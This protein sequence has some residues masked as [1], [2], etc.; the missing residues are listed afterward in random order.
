MNK[1]TRMPEVNSLAKILPS[2]VDGGKEFAR[3]V[4][5]LLFY[6][7][8]RN[9]DTVNLFSDRSGD[10]YGLDSVQENFFRTEKTTGYQYKF[11]SSPLSDNHRREIVAAVKK[12]HDNQKH[13]KLKKWILVTPDDLIESST[14]RLGGDVSWFQNLKSELG[15]K[16]NIEHWGHRKLQALFI[17][18]PRL[19]LYYY[20]EL[21][22]EGVM[23]RK[24]IL[25]IRKIYD[26]NFSE[27]H[28]RIDFIGMSVYKPE[29]THGVPLEEIYIPVSAVPYKGA[30]TTLTGL[31][32]NPLEFL[33]P[34]SRH[35]VLGDPGSGKSTLLKFLSIVGQSSALQERYNAKSDKR[36]PLIIILRKYSDAL[37]TNKNISLLQFICQTLQADYSIAD[38]DS[39]FVEYF[40]ESGQ[41]IILFDGM[42]EL[43]DASFKQVVRDRINNFLNCY[44]FVTS[45]ITSRIV[46]Y[47]AAFGFDTER[48]S[49]HQ[50][51]PLLLSEIECFIK[52]WY[53]VRIENKADRQSN[54]DHLLKIFNNPEQ[55]AIRTLAENPLLLTIV[56]LV[57][58]IDAV[59]PD[60]RVVLYQKC[61]E[62]L[63]NTWHTWKYKEAEDTARRGRIERTNRRRIENLAY[64]MHVQ[65]GAENKKSRA[66]LSEDEV[67]SVLIKDIVKHDGTTDYA[68]ARDISLEFLEFIKQKAGLLIEVGDRQY[69]F[70]HLTFQEY[71]TATSLTVDMEV[72][73]V[74][75]LLKKLKS[76][77]SDPRWHEVIRLLI[78]GLRSDESQEYIISHMLEAE[79]T[80]P[81]INISSL[82]GG[83]LIDGVKSAEHFKVD[84]ISLLFKYAGTE[85]ESDESSKIIDLLRTLSE[86]YGD[87]W[88]QAFIATWRSVI[89]L[90]VAMLLLVFAIR[91]N[92][93]RWVELTLPQI[94]STTSFEIEM[95]TLLFGENQIIAKPCK[96][97][98]KK[99]ATYQDM[100]I[101]AALRNRYTNFLSVV[102]QSLFSNCEIK[103][104]HR[105]FL[106]LLISVFKRPKGPFNDLFFNITVLSINQSP[107]KSALEVAQIKT[108]KSYR[109]TKFKERPMPDRMAP[110]R[111]PKNR[112]KR[113][114]L[115][116]LIEE[117][118]GR[119]V[120]NDLN[121]E[122]EKGRKEIQRDTI[123][124][125]V[126]NGNIVHYRVFDGPLSDL[127]NKIALRFE[128]D[129][130]DAD[131]YRA[132][133]WRS[134]VFSEELFGPYITSLINN[135]NLK[136][137]FLW[138]ESIRNSF[139][140]N[141]LERFP[142]L[143]SKQLLLLEEKFIGGEL[144]SEDIFQAASFHLYDIWLRYFDGYDSI[145]NSPIE[146]L[147]RLAAKVKSPELDIARAMRLIAFDET[148][149]NILK[150]LTDSSKEHLAVLANKRLV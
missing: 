115:I 45:L 37:K 94:L 150:E 80:N 105:S 87:A 113:E 67:I 38:A 52:D 50:I 79:H 65:A 68:E 6:A 39:D 4:D 31:R 48:Y 62:T 131:Q 86:K 139:L 35:V 29:A 28:N 32:T 7:A 89:D 9:G 25:E 41:A 106:H 97:L 81:D 145:E 108:L 102:G 123:P 3:I 100:M 112:V 109:K 72:G 44:P 95:F 135:F 132:E 111:E 120:D 149:D 122:K 119:S 74:R 63:L 34:G 78:A 24:T 90:R 10:Y 137:S 138:G 104:Q 99:L 17:E 93:S 64:Y 73:G 110:S 30:Q 12:A 36:L 70:I 98:Q 54:I 133:N 58:R 96:E 125:N 11:F 126:M 26:A 20:P 71:L 18:T 136:P 23:K 148:E 128:N 57:H 49:H 21:V 84:I 69:S 129:E 114:Y 91:I 22:A 118:V 75:L 134:S 14:R 43:P 76:H 83:L 16:F 19:C 142:K 101:T 140:S 130:L 51:A 82:L 77:L 46:G 47:S 15:L 55:K 33:K 61:T 147:A 107:V 116:Q 27:T 121:I 144:S 117:L 5:L 40:L 1:I 103:E 2:G 60:E 146:N 8:N 88:N 143:D 66:V 13:L 53:R 42:D 56:A 59:L 124:L 141:A 127:I 92:S 85:T